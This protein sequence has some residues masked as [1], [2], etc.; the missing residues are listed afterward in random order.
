MYRGTVTTEHGDRYTYDFGG[1]SSATPA[2][3]GTAALMRSVNEDLSWRDLKLILAAT[4]RNSEPDSPGWE[5]GGQKYM[6]ESEDDVYEFNE[7]YG[8]GVVDAS[9]AVGMAVEW[10]SVP[11]MRTASVDSGRLNASITDPAVS[12]DPDDPGVLLLEEVVGLELEAEIDFTEF[13]EVNVELDHESFRDLYIWLES[14]SGTVST[15]STP[16]DTF[17]DRDPSID[18]VALDGAFRFGSAKHLGEDPNGEWK[19]GVADYLGNGIEGELVSFEITVYGHEHVPGVPWVV[20]VIELGGALRAWW[21]S[22]DEYEGPEVESYDVRYIET[23]ED[24]SDDENWTEVEEAW[25]SEDGG[26]LAYRIEDLTVGTEYGVQVRSVNRSGPGPWSETRTGTPWEPVFCENG[27]VTD[28]EDN[29]GLVSDCELLLRSRDTLSGSATL[30]WREELAMSEWDGVTLSGT[31]E[32]VTRLELQNEG[33]DGEIAVELSW[34]SELRLLYLHRNSLSGEIPAELGKL[35]KLER[36]YLHD[37]ELSGEIPDELAYISKLTHLLLLNNELSGEIPATLGRMSNLVWLA[38][39]GNE[40]SG[41]I[42]TS[43]GDL[44]KLRTLYL[45]YNDL[46]GQIPSELGKLTALTNLWLNNNKLSGEIPASLGDLTNLERWRLRNNNFTGC[47][48]AGLAAVSDS[49][50]AALGLDACPSQ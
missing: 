43:L 34:V 27:A 16:F 8:F 18:H 38:L 1:T 24:A 28:A 30:N 44:E 10:T 50:L 15:L 6:S 4:A 9:A 2:V 36:L 17:N 32:R 47:V 14:P 35:T 49:D 29:P 42:P 46:T 20:G 11:R 33:L 21:T 41:S 19:L 48:P 7:E 26:E 22:P 31:P 37:N 25:T 23:A 39:Y 5:D 12:V 45:H 3:S 13:V 40:L